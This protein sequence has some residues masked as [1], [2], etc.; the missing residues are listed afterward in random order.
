[1]HEKSRQNRDDRDDDEDF[2]E[3][4]TGRAT[5][6]ATGRRGVGDANASTGSEHGVPSRWTEQFSVSP[7]NRGSQPGS[8]GDPEER[9]PW[10]VALRGAAS[11]NSVTTGF[12]AIGAADAGWSLVSPGFSRRAGPGEGDSFPRGIVRKEVKAN[13]EPG[14]TSLPRKAGGQGSE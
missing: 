5:G 6:H 14:A 10:G 8:A 1:R 12:A 11:V 2:H 13:G 3:R 9:S 4:E 7:V